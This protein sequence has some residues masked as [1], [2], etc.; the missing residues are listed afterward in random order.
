MGQYMRLGSCEDRSI[1]NAKGQWPYRPPN[2]TGSTM[3]P[4]TDLYEMTQ[5]RTPIELIVNQRYY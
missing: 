5:H 4:P 3:S 2:E 1:D